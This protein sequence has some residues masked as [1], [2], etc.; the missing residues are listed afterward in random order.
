MSSFVTGVFEELEEECRASMIYDNMDLSRLMVHAQQIEKSC[1]R[2][3]NRKAKRA[4]SF[5]SGFCE[6][7]LDVQDKIKFK[8]RF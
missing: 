3:R 4:K 5:K 8:K 7:R 2:K 6:S 1:L